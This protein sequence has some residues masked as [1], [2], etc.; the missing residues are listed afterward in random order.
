MKNAT[1]T[2]DSPIDRSTIFVTPSNISE[3]MRPLSKLCRNVNRKKGQFRKSAGQV[4]C[5]IHGDQP[6]DWGHVKSTQAELI[7]YVIKT[8][9][10]PISASEIAYRQREIMMNEGGM[11]PECRKCNNLKSNTSDKDRAK[12]AR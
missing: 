10:F 12:N 8:S 1:K 9:T 11:I 3:V 5:D 6:A 4:C 7:E 2:K